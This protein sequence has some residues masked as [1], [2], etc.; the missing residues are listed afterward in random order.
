MTMSAIIMP[1]DTL[2]NEVDAVENFQWLMQTALSREAF[3][4]NST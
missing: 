4:T 2:D 3:C 1:E